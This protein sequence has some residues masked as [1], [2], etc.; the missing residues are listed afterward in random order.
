[1]D[2][3]KIKLS[4]RLM[5]NMIAK[6]ISKAIFKKFG[7][8]PELRINEIEIEMIDGKMRFHIDVDGET[9]KNLFLKI[10]QM[11]DKD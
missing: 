4:T 10:T 11:V 3:M 1:M 7:F 2:E 6:I 9:D 8:K 5:R